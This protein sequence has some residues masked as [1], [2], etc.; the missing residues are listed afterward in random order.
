MPNSRP[1][2]T[3]SPKRPNAL[4]RLLDLHIAHQAMGMMGATRSALLAE[5]LGR[6][7]QDGTVGQATREPEDGEIQHMQVHVGPATTYQQSP[8]SPGEPTSGRRNDSTRNAK[9]AAIL[10]GALAA[11]G[12]GGYGAHA[13][14]NEPSEPASQEVV[15]PADATPRYQIRL[16]QGE[17]DAEPEVD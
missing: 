8:G 5:R 7:T 16:S 11:G 13:L 6:K 2:Q 10:A 9:W 14:M 15:A 17:L 12:A 4:E 1:E 3:P